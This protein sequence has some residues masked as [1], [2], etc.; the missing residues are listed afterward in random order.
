MLP[1]FVGHH[2]HTARFGLQIGKSSAFGAV[3]F[4]DGLRNLRIDFGAGDGFQCV[5]TLVFLGF[6]KNREVALSQQRRARELTERESR[7]F[8]NSLAEAL[9]VFAFQNF[10]VVDLIVPAAQFNVGALQATIGLI[11]GSPLRIKSAVAH[12]FGKEGDFAFHDP[13]AARHGFV[14]AARQVTQAWRTAV[15]RNADG[16]KQ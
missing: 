11:A 9:L 13:C 8:F 14:G 16:V 12:A 7:D 4:I 10:P 1:F 3:A 15:K 2:A 6:Q 5:G